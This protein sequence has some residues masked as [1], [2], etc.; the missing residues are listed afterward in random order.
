MKINKFLLFTGIFLLILFVSKVVYSSQLVPDFRLNI[1][2][3]QAGDLTLTLNSIG[4]AE[5]P[6]VGYQLDYSTNYYVIKIVDKNNVDLFTGKTLKSAQ[7]LPPEFV[8]PPVTNFTSE[9]IILDPINLYLPYFNDATKV[10]I[11]D[12]NGTLKLEINLADHNLVGIKPRFAACDLC[13]Y[14]PPDKLPSNWESCRQCLYPQAS[15]DPSTGD[16]LRIYDTT[17]QS[18]PT[19]FPGKS[20]TDIGCIGIAPSQSTQAVL[21]IIFSLAGGIAFLILLYGAF[22]VA[23]SQAEP[24]KLIYGKRLVKG[25]VIGL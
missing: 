11:F 10:Q 16:T 8:T 9:T 15:T 4:L 2:I 18:G 6:S 23:T 17:D 22:V 3:N 25:A 20:F 24:E 7:T 5:G 1:I 21:N 12:E 19:T 13:G 14:C